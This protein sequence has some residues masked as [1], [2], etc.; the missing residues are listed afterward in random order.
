MSNLISLAGLANEIHETLLS[1]GGD[2]TPELEL[3]LI[4]LESKLP[5]KAD[6]YAYV[7]EDLA[8][9]VDMLKSRAKI[10]AHAAKGLERHIDW[11]KAKMKSA[12]EI[13]DGQEIRGLEHRWKLMGA[14]DRVI[15]DDESLI[16]DR[17]METTIIRTPMKDILY[18]ELKLDKPIPGC[19]LESSTYAKSYI[20]TK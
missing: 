15:I 14:K 4:E 8:H 1:N 11:M 5:N 6:G 9:K 16:P 7:C 13:I 17:Y 19:H 10:Y 3:K 2:L 12:L 20:N 18:M